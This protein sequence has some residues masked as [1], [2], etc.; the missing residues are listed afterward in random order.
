MT[1]E[2][3]VDQVRG[4]NLDEEGSLTFKAGVLLFYGIYN[5]DLSYDFFCTS[6]LDH[7][8]IGII[9]KNL[10]I[11]KILVGSRLGVDFDPEEG[12]M[13]FILCS[14]AGAGVLRREPDMKSIHLEDFESEELFH[15]AVH[16]KGSK[17]RL[18]PL[19]RRSVRVI[20][21]GQD[22][23]VAPIE[24]NGSVFFGKVINYTGFYTP[25]TVLGFDVKSII[26]ISG[27]KQ[28]EMQELIA[29]IIEETTQTPPSREK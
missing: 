14:M 4:M 16:T 6:G 29:E 24:L 3:C 2:E 28:K 19:P 20:L 10:R 11:N 15:M 26:K 8:D 18:L 12:W 1:F 27:Y 23:W 5:S 17:E 7:S 13:E 25:G 22:Y 21:D 9:L